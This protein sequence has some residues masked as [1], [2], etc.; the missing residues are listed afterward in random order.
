MNPIVEIFVIALAIFGANVMQLAQLPS[1]VKSD[2]I[3]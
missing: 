1:K 3:L 2:K